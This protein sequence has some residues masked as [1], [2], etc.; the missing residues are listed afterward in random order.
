[1]KTLGLL[2]T[3]L[4]T[5]LTTVTANE[6]PT[7]D[8]TNA[9][10]LS[11]YHQ[12]Q[13]IM[14]V[15]RGIEFIVFPNGDFDFNTAWSYGYDNTYSNDVYY[16]TT[17]N[18]RRGAVNTTRGPRTSQYS[19]Y[20]PANTGVQIVR[21]R[22]GNVRRVGNVFINYDFYGRVNRIGSVFINYNR[23]LLVQVGGLHLI[24]NTQGHLIN[25]RG[26]VN[27]NWSENHTY[28]SF[29]Y[30]DHN[31]WDNDNDNFYYYKKDGKTVK[32]AKT[33]T[34]RTRE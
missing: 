3:V 16:R 11:R 13:P 12:A 15:E 2:F 25:T 14:F 32:K 22:F 21:D 7:L 26:Q 23:N 1:M 6:L 34:R 33:L 28:N 8:G 27:Y 20:G 24:Y 19:Y 5:G 4:L 10:T 31:V 29:G 18:T 17:N 30:D 9:T